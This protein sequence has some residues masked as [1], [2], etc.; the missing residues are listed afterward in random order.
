MYSHPKK[1]RANFL[2]KMM[3]ADHLTDVSQCARDALQENNRTMRFAAMLSHDGSAGA[4]S[5]LR[6]D[7]AT[8]D[9]ME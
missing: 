1:E 5:W 7:S 3:R 9:S 2:T 8:S 6:T 4:V